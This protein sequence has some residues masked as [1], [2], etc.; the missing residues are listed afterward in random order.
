MDPFGYMDMQKFLSSG[1]RNERKSFKI[2]FTAYICYIPKCKS[3]ALNW[4]SN[5]KIKKKEYDEISTKFEH[6]YQLKGFV[7]FHIWI[8]FCISFEMLWTDSRSKK[9]NSPLNNIKRH[10]FTIDIC[11][12]THQTYHMWCMKKAPPKFE[13]R[14]IYWSLAD[15][16]DDQRSQIIC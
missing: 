11:Y 16:D 3:A 10:T 7:S 14:C 1:K 13:L 5:E 12:R 4:N 15:F 8:W 6:A 9:T 2:Y